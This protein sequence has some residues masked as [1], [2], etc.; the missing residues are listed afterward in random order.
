MS[1]SAWEQWKSNLGDT[2]PWDLWDPSIEKASDDKASARFEICS[3][4]PELLKIS[5]QCKKC[6]CFMALKTKL[7]GAVCPIGKW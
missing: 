7:E 6:G 1:I 5:K 4:C 3:S 2:R